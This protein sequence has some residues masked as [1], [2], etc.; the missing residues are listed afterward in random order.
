MTRIRMALMLGLLLAL[1][2]AVAACGGGGKPSG[3]ASLKGAG[4]AT[5]TT[6][7][8]GGDDRQAALNYARCMRQHGID[9]PDPTFDAQGH[10]AIQNPPGVGPDNPKFKAA[11]QACQKY[12][13]NGG[14]PQ[15]PNPQE[16]QQ[17]LAFAR[18]MRQHGVNMP[19]PKLEANGR[20][21]WRLPS[22]I[23]KDDPRLKAA[24][25]A[26]RQYRANGG[27]A[28]R[29][30]PQQQQEMLAYARCMRQHGI[31]IPDPQPDGRVDTSGVNPDDPKFKAAERACPGFRPKY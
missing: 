3:V 23:R 24:Q 10:L 15:K 12:L 17:M 22:G 1:A 20:T 29:P 14:A 5:A 9:L 19:D 16:Q 26:C 18:C 21:E 25:Q 8:G 11:N 6:R 4:K 27:Q 7:A 30:S 28:Q 2:L 31:N 13:P